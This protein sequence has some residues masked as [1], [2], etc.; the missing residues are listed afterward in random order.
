MKT[1]KYTITLVFALIASAVF[2][3]SS[4]NGLG[5]VGHNVPLTGTTNTHYLGWNDS[6]I[7]LQF[8]TNNI[9]RMELTKS[10]TLLFPGFQTPYSR[11]GFLGI[12]ATTNFFNMGAF[13]LLHLNGDN[14]TSLPQQ[15]GFRPWMK[16]GLTF[17]TNR[18]LMFV[19]MRARGGYDDSEAVISWSDNQNFP[20]P[21]NLVFKFTA[22]LSD[23]PQNPQNT[24]GGLEVARFSPNGNVGIGN[25]SADSWGSG[26]S[27]GQGLD[28]QPTHRLDVDGEV[29]IRRMQLDSMPDFIITGMFADS[30]S[31]DSG[32]FVLKYSSPSG[33]NDCDWAIND[34][35]SMIVAATELFDFPEG[36]CTRSGLY[37]VGIGLQYAK[38]AKLTVYDDNSGAI[39]SDIFIGVASIMNKYP[40]DSNQGIYAFNGEAQSPL[41]RFNLGGHF[42]GRNGNNQ[43]FG[44]HGV[45]YS[46]VQ[47][48]WGLNAVNI[49]VY[50]EAFGS[51]TSN[52]AGY[53]AG[54]VVTNG[55]SISVSDEMFKEDIVEMINA[56]EIIN[57]LNPKL[58]NFKCEEYPYMHLDEGQHC[59]LIAQE[60]EEVMPMLVS[61]VIFPEQYDS[62]GIKCADAIEFKG[63]NYTELIPILIQATK[64]QQQIID[65]K[66]EEI[67]QLQDELEEVWA[68]QDD[69]WNNQDELW[70]GQEELWNGQGELW[71]NSEVSQQDMWNNME[72]MQ[73]QIDE[74]WNLLGQC[75]ES[76]S[77]AQEN[78]LTT[79]GD[80]YEL[81]QNTPN[82]FDDYTNI[83]WKMAEDAQ[84][85]I[86]VQDMSGRLVTTLVEESSTKGMHSVQWNTSDLPAG[87][88]FYSLHVNGEMQVKRAVKIK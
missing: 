71:E 74:L 83:S 78:N 14:G 5:N 22:G 45:A 31:P 34:N 42:E 61:D 75:C 84:A 15:N 87:T 3:Q 43:N 53:F 12:S 35:T 50:G 39:N 44:V 56:M 65:E 6:D 48:G 28:Q 55:S 49:G 82:P 51:N 36:Q 13:S 21:D 24:N 68:A 88:Y 73:A 54:S 18:D 86:I 46:D 1:I 63:V 52:F 72:Q 16:Y 70:Q 26:Q 37:K 80:S 4:I 67:A 33:L 41:A 64:E 57:S 7:P 17:T 19:G 9:V 69:I 10:S 76:K 20:S 59:G 85:K 30:L 66:D 32:D 2:S 25:F 62:L 38:D 58:Y 8:R 79:Q 81:F 11:N 29:R 47:N 23:T 40:D 77:A 60:L 27:A